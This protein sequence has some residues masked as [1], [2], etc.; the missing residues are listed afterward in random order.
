MVNLV[1]QVTVLILDEVKVLNK[2]AW[3]SKNLKFI[4]IDMDESE[5]PSVHD[6]GES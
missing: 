4:G 3:N 6:I 5:R 1:P 2:I